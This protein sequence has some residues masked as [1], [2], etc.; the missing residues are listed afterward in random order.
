MLK[1]VEQRLAKLRAARDV[2][3]TE[4]A[5]LESK[6]ARSQD[7]AHSCLDKLRKCAP[8]SPPVTAFW[9]PTNAQSCVTGCGSCPVRMKTADTRT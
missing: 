3:A 2:M 6:Q 8:A 1:Q 7:L 9:L 5:D 4:C